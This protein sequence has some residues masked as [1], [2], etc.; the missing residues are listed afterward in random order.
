MTEK[1]QLTL[2]EGMQLPLTLGLVAFSAWRRRIFPLVGGVIRNPTFIGAFPM[3]I[4]Q[5]IASYFFLN[6]C[7]CLNSENTAKIQSL[8]NIVI[9]PAVSKNFPIRFLV[10]SALNDRNCCLLLLCLMNIF[11]QLLCE[12]WSRNSKSS[13]LHLPTLLWVT[14]WVSS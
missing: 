4:P 12:A 6:Q 10:L 13:A 8:T 3:S 1:L 7:S 11:K 14:F 9:Q 5:C 2:E